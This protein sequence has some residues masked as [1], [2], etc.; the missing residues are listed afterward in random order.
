[1]TWRL[2]CV[3]NLVGMVFCGCPSNTEEVVVSE[4]CNV[5]DDCKEG[6]FCVFGECER[7]NITI[8]IMSDAGSSLSFVD[9]DSG[10]IQNSAIDSGVITSLQDSGNGIIVSDSGQQSET[11]SSD[12]G[13]HLSSEE[14][15]ASITHIDPVIVDE[16]GDAGANVSNDAG[17]G[18]SG[19]ATSDPVFEYIKNA[20]FE[21]FEFDAES[22]LNFPTGWDF[23]STSGETY[24]VIETTDEDRLHV[25][26]IDRT[27]IGDH[28]AMMTQTSKVNVGSCDSLILSGD[29]RPM[30]QG[31]PS[32]GPDQG[33]FPVHLRIKYSDALGELYT[34]QIGIYFNGN[35]IDSFTVTEDSCA[36][37]LGNCLD[38]LTIKVSQNDWFSMPAIDL[39]GL[40]PQPQMIRSFQLGSSGTSFKAQF[41]NVQI[42]GTGPDTCGIENMGSATDANTDQP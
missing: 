35:S 13:A 27:L 7:Q 41:D 33:Q 34:F 18:N 22:G 2:M 16:T 23:Q 29:V 32:P 37:E 21:L 1:M 15:D 11:N 3:M 40:E 36:A 39:M 9:L 30:Q 42:Y 25:M 8:P 10:E 12:A 4:K 31:L 24:S 17:T 26:E 6:E 19:T 14:M 28:W 20:D 5:H 38:F